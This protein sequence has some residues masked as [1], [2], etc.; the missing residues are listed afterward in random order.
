MTTSKDALKILLDRGKLF[1]QDNI[2][3]LIDRLQESP[4]DSIIDS[5]IDKGILSFKTEKNDIKTVDMNPDSSTNKIDPANALSSEINKTIDSKGNTILTFSSISGKKVGTIKINK[6]DSAQGLDKNKIIKNV[7]NA[8]STG[9]VTT[10]NFINYN[11]A[12][13]YSI[14]IFDK[15]Q[16]T[17][18]D[19]KKVIS[20]I[21]TSEG[22]ITISSIDGTQMGDI[23]NPAVNPGNNAI[24][25]T[26]SN[27]YGK[28]GTINGLSGTS[29][30]KVSVMVPQS[31]PTGDDN[32]NYKTLGLYL[33]DPLVFGSSL[34]LDL[35]TN[36]D[37]TF[38]VN[39]VISSFGALNTNV[40]SYSRIS[41]SPET[42]STVVTQMRTKELDLY[43][44]GAYEFFWIF[45]DYSDGESASFNF[46][47]STT[48]SFSRADINK[49]P[50]A[51]AI[52]KLFD[53]SAAMG[54]VFA[55]KKFIGEVLLPDDNDGQYYYVRMYLQLQKDTVDTSKDAITIGY[56]AQNINKLVDLSGKKSIK[57]SGF[58][59]T[60]KM[61]RQEKST[62]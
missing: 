23:D 54:D 42:G 17:Y 32:N 10:Y 15:P 61:H 39:D 29:F 27:V 43:T 36:S 21:D 59:I 6:I 58:P 24:Y 47:I 8:G 50:G 26:I 49:N 4:D 56:L 46:P 30:K 20:T 18:I 60:F 11:G 14:Q 48:Q 53:N 12:V 55:S 25:D 22:K 3:Q 44:G 31:M 19:Q 40:G 62:S 2:Y 33:K 57:I 41:L 38:T 9:G 13:I 45:G 34:L 51:A 37:K 35:S 52:F 5:S 16:I 28:D 7:V 1:E